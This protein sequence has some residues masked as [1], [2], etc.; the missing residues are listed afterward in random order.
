MMEVIQMLTL[1]LVLRDTIVPMEQ[2]TIRLGHV[3]LG[4]II[5]KKEPLLL[6]IV[7]FARQELSVKPMVYHTLL[8]IA[9]QVR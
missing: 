6:M 3:K 5:L 8:A 1:L 7:N 2:P 9:L 4:L